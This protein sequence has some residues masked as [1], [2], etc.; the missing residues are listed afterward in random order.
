MSGNKLVLFACL[1]TLVVMGSAY[2]V[3]GVEVQGDLTV[4]GTG[5]L[6]FPDGTKQTTA[7]APTWHQ[8]LTASRFVSVMG[9]AAQLDNETGLVWATSPDLTTRT[10]DTAVSY[11]YGLNLGG[12]GGWRLPTIAELR[13]L[14]DP[15]RAD[16]ALP[17]SH[18]FMTIASTYYWSSSITAFNTDGAWLLNIGSGGV[19]TSLKTGT[20]YVWPVRGGQ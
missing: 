12:R 11:C 10:W 7:A 15:T 1:M 4:S 6:V 13:S 18:P 20:Y 14:A 19:D 16:P 2:A 3:P 8:I 5:G 9:G 17:A